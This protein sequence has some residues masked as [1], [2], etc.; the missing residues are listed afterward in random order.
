MYASH[1]V[2]TTV[3]LSVNDSSDEV[4]FILSTP[5]C[6]GKVIINFLIE[7][8]VEVHERKLQSPS[9]GRVRS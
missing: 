5:S 6:T 8:V 2:D 7:T 4:Q 1:D 3:C 9:F